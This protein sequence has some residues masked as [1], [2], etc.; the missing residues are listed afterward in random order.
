MAKQDRDIFHE[1]IAEAALRF[2]QSVNAASDRIP[3]P[4]GHPKDNQ[5]WKIT[6]MEQ[7]RR[8]TGGK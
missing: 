8:L 7:I 5:S 6:S 3:N 2:F 4:P 1:S